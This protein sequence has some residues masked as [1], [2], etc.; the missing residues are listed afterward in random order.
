MM[1]VSDDDERIFADAG[2]TQTKG[3]GG[4]IIS[5]NQE[6]MEKILNCA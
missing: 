6:V 5:G 3:V 4:C 1:Y 2:S